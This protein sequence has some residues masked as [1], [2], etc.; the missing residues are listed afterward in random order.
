MAPRELKD[1]FDRKSQKIIE[2]EVYKSERYLREMAHFRGDSPDIQVTLGGCEYFSVRFQMKFRDQ[3]DVHEHA[4]YLE[5]FV[6]ALS[7]VPL[8]PYGQKW[9][10]QLL[11]VLAQG[12]ENK[13][14]VNQCYF[15]A[16]PL[17]DSVYC[18]MER[19]GPFAVM[20]MSL[21]TNM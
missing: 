10:R 21:D 9:T 7:L 5:Q 15:S 17:P 12:M 19:V 8:S 11:D 2:I 1:F 6:S 13:V 16:K 18:Q 20:S 14:A 3:T 4:F